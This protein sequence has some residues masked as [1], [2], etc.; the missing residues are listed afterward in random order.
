MNELSADIDAND[1]GNLHYR[2]IV[3]T[4]IRLATQAEPL[5]YG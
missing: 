1:A 2:R 4:R 3:S 5:E